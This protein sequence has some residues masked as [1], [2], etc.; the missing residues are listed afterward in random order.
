MNWLKQNWQ[1]IIY[2]ILFVWLALNAIAMGAYQAGGIGTIIMVLISGLLA[3]YF[4]PFPGSTWRKD[5]EEIK[6]LLDKH[7]EQRGNG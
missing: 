3:A 4:F 7:D 6:K 5:K 2:Q 1:E